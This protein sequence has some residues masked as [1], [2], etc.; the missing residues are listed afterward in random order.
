MRARAR[1]GVGSLH[2]ET[3]PAQSCASVRVTGCDQALDYAPPVHPYWLDEPHRQGGPLNIH[4]RRI[5][6]PPPPIAFLAVAAQIFGS[7]FG[8]QK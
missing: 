5:F 3:S 7:V 1:H 6:L 4:I 2:L 8:K